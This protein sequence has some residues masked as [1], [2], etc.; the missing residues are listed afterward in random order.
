MNGTHGTNTDSTKHQNP[1]ATNDS[2]SK[3]S[4]FRLRANRNLEITTTFKP[5]MAEP[6][7]FTTPSETP[8]SDSGKDLAETNNTSDTSTPIQPV[9]AEPRTFTAAP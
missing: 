9:M 2:K 4:N 6:K 8:T 1:T 3:K 7:T 5:V